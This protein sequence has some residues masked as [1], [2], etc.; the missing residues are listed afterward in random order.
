MIV[1]NLWYFS[2]ISFH[3]GD[4]LSKKM[5][6]FIGYLFKTWFEKDKQV[7]VLKLLNKILRSSNL[8]IFRAKYLK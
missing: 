7:E 1:E 4:N 8:V 6:N 3:E 5:S 2:M